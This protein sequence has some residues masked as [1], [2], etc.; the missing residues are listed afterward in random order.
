M[1]VRRAECAVHARAGN[2]FTAA[3][4]AGPA[5]RFRASSHHG[6]LVLLT[7]SPGLGFLSVVTGVDGTTVAGVPAVLAAAADAG[8]RT[9]TVVTSTRSP[10]VDD[11]LGRW[12]LRPVGTR[13]IAVSVLGAGR[14]R[15]GAPGAGPVGLRVDEVRTP[16][17]RAVFLDVVLAGYAAQ[18]EVTE[19]VR[20]D[21]SGP[22][23]RAFLASVGGRPVAAAA[24][25]V[26]HGVAVLGGAATL[27]T[28]RGSGI[29]RALLVHRLRAAEEAGAVMATATAAPA[30]PSLRNL[31]R[32]GFDLHLR[33]AWQ[34]ASAG[35]G[36]R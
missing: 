27:P 23:V 9:P 8:F 30:S 17:D 19:L 15:P 35:G 32:T 21:H 10:A 1:D 5:G 13:P 4:G 2:S 25:T 34:D 6:L 18:P 29:Q 36:R 31:E 20:A 11:R 7:D 3:E 33:R 22:L 12:G 14:A 16:D 26:Q 28:H 24:M